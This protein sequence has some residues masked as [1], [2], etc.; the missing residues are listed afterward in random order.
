MH[1]LRT[2]SNWKC[3]VKMKH[4]PNKMKQRRQIKHEL[5]VYWAYTPEG[6]I[7][8]MVTREGIERIVTD[9]AWKVFNTETCLDDG[10][11]IGGTGGQP[12]GAAPSNRGTGYHDCYDEVRQT[13]NDCNKTC[14]CWLKQNETITRHENWFRRIAGIKTSDKRS[15]SVLGNY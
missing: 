9:T 5:E 2:R 10:P 7:A 4:W 13:F 14:I 8:K 3:S 6:Q 12:G 15:G 11:L 1:L